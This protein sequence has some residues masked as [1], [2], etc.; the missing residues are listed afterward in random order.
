MITYD[1]DDF[2]NELNEDMNAGVLSL[3]QSIQVQRDYQNMIG[4]YAPIVDWYYSKEVMEEQYQSTVLDTAEEKEELEDAYRMYNLIKNSLETMTVLDAV[5][6]MKSWNL[7][8]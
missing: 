2:L 4:D 3:T 1:Y 8:G 7:N 5:K 6:E